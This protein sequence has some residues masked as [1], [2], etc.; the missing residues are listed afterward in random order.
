MHE[1]ALL[2][3]FQSGVEALLTELSP[4]RIEK[5]AATTGRGLFS[6][7]DRSTV[8]KRR[9]SDLADEEN[10]RFRLVFGPEFVEEY[11]QFMGEPPIVEQPE[12]LRTMP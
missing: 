1:V 12:P 4:T 11:R 6:R 9:H 10:E 3:G 2:N 8:Y 5:A 7:V